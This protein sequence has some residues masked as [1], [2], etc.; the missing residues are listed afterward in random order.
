MRCLHREPERP[1]SLGSWNLDARHDPKASVV[2]MVQDQPVGH[3]SLSDFSMEPFAFDDIT[4]NVFRKGSGPA[5]IVMAEV[6]G[7]TPTVA[8]FARRV[9]DRGMTVYM[10]DLFGVA[11]APRTNANAAK[12]LARICISK[13]FQAFALRTTAPVV[14]WLRAL[15]RKAVDDTGFP[16]VGAV[17]MCFTGGFAL[18]MAT[19]PEMLAPVMSQPSLPVFFRRGAKTDPGCSD[20][21]LL[22]ITQRCRAGE[23]KVMGLHFSE[24]RLAP[25]ERFAMLHHALGSAFIEVPIN[26]GKGNPSGHPRIAH[27]V[28]TEDLIDVPGEPTHKALMDVL[29]FLENRLSEV[30]SK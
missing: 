19:E 17:G 18:A 27:S 22:Q 7:I 8:D 4:H 26:S 30:S 10:P 14:E 24:D 9:V 28:L 15:A 1:G 12:V 29:D 20:D 23:L 11:G 2:A 5:V 3:D 25:K 16:G 13:E 6:P 21:D